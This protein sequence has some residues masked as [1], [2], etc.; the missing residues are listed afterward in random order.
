MNEYALRLAKP[1]CDNCH[2][3]KKEVWT[4]KL[5]EIGLDLANNSDKSLSLA[6]R[7]QQ[8][9]QLAKTNN[10]EEEDEI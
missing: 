7:L 2:H 8:T 9:I 3:P 6:D 10:Q 4:P 1:H 5:E